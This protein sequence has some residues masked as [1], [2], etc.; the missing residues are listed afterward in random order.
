MKTHKLFQNKTAI[1]LAGLFL[2]SSVLRYLFSVLSVN[3]PTV[4]IDEGLYI[5]IARSLF[6]EGKVLYRAQ[7]ISYV[8]LGYPIALLPLFLLP[9]SVSLY[10]AVQAYNALLISTSVFPAYLLGKKMDLGS[11]KSFLLAL[12]TALV[13]E[14]ALS[15]FLTA[16]SLYYPLMIWSF[17][18]V[19]GICFE[20]ERGF[21]HYLPLALIT[22]FSFF[23]KPVCVIFGVCFCILDIVRSIRSKDK[24]SAVSSISCLALTAAL[25]AL[26]Y[27]LYN[28]LF[29]SATVLNLYE[30]QLEDTTVASIPLM[31]QSILYHSIAFVFACGGAFVLLPWFYKSKFESGR[32]HLMNAALF[33]ILA[34]I[35]GV[36]VMVVPY[37]YADS[38]FTSSVHLRYIMYYFPLVFVFF[39][40]EDCSG[41]LLNKKKATIWL[42]SATFLTIFPSAFNFFNKN[43][44]TYNSPALNAFYKQRIDLWIGIVL[45]ILSVNHTAFILKRIW[46]GKLTYQFKRNSCIILSVFFLANGVCTYSAR[47]TEGP[48]YEKDATELAGYIADKE[49]VLIATTNHYD[50]FS[51]FLLD[52]HLHKPIQMVVMNELLLNAIPYR[53]LCSMDST[54]T[55]P[56]YLQ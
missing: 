19:A 9:S 11:K 20:K 5:N 25:I 15:S 34:S 37:K 49:N 2:L 28:V 55:G 23:V 39:L 7:P 47:I 40:S 1:W 50:N 51:G 43:A 17:Y 30:K 41:R 33:G 21:K 6:N 45:I 42:I 18:I 44:G 32:Q 36:A 29:G 52:A 13:P 3:M 46:N 56:Q 22:G 24:K 10:R 48:M 14:M 12:F 31:F 8:Y 38:G 4:Y 54:R 26:G 16:E 53:G 35:I 27:L